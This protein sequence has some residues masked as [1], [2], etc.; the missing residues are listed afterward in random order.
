MAYA[1]VQTVDDGGG[2]GGSSTTATT[3]NFSPNP[4]TGNLIVVKV[5][6]DGV[7]TTATCA[8]TRGNSYTQLGTGLRDANGTSTHWFYAWNITGGGTNAATVTFGAT[9]AFR[10]ITAQEYSG[11]R[12]T[13]DPLVGFNIGAAQNGPGTANDAITSGNGTPTAQPALAWGA[14]T[15]GGSTDVASAAGTGYGGL[16]TSAKTNIGYS[17]SLEHKRITATTATAATFTFNNAGGGSTFATIV[18]FFAESGSSATTV[19]PAPASLSIA[20]NAPATSAFSSVRIRE[21][22]VNESGQVVGNAANIR[23]MV[24]Y[25]AQCKGQPDVSLNGMTTDAAGTTSWSIATG[26]LAFNDP[27]F[28]VAQDSISFSNY[29][30]ARMIPSYE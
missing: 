12:T 7:L 25:S 28:Y 21:V 3:N 6:Y 11:I 13:S 22:L 16:A 1:L 10:G 14:T 9:R 24:W 30:A 19:T 23:L 17:H 20:G 4:T 15:N 5:T 29:T 27:I 2:I 18:A 26:T 8:D